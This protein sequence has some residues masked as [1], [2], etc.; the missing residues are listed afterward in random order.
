VFG[1]PF[2]AAGIYA[3]FVP[4]LAPDKVNG[5]VQLVYWAAAVFGLA[6]LYMIWI[7]IRRLLRRAGA[8]RLRERHPA[9][10]WLWDHPWGRH[11]AHGDVRRRAL[12]AVMGA[13]AFAVFLAPFN[14]IAFGMD[15]VPAGA[16]WIGV[17]VVFDLVTIGIVVHAAYLVMRWLKYGVATVTFSR[18]PFVLGEEG[19][20]HFQGTARGEPPPT[21]TVTLRCVEEAYETTGTGKNRSTQTV[22]Y[23]VYADTQTV[24]DVQ[25]LWE[26]RRGVALSFTF[27]A[28]ASATRLSERPPRYWELEIGAEVPG[29]DY[30][31]RFLLPVYA[32]RPAS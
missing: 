8:A 19:T 9:E 32:V 16:L 29:I 23:E 17:V 7:G 21:L 26:G 5:P 25:A 31:G 3:A 13:G 20:I 6:G 14:V 24:D 12:A 30:Q 2:L 1:L 15:G 28:D 11:G 22:C 18:F 27:P 4:R 10:P